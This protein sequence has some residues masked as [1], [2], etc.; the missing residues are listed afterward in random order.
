MPESPILVAQQ[1]AVR[2]LTLNRPSSLNSFTGDMHEQ[3]RARLHDVAADAS[4]RCLLIT[5]AGR[6]FCAGQ[7]LADPLV[8]PGPAG[9]APRDLGQVIER[10]YKPLVLQ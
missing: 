6:A 5:G 1:G 4:L 8:A 10:L 3:L 7:D 9:T 2:T